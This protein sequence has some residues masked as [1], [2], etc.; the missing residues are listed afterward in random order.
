MPVQIHH[1]SQ[2]LL[3]PLDAGREL[4]R[5]IPGARF[6]IHPGA[7]HGLFERTDEVGESILAFLAEYEAPLSARSGDSGRRAKA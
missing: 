6:E 5:R 4:A 2:D 3:I 7:G 1:G